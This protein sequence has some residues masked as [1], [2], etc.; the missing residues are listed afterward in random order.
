MNGEYI[1]IIPRHGDAINE[2]VF[3]KEATLHSIHKYAKSVLEF[4]EKSMSTHVWTFSAPIPNRIKERRFQFTGI[5]FQL[6]LTDKGFDNA[7]HY[8]APFSTYHIDENLGPLSLETHFN[9]AIGY[10]FQLYFKNSYQLKEK[11]FIIIGYVRD[12]SETDISF[13]TGWH[14]YISIGKSV[15]LLQLKVPGKKTFEQNSQHMPNGI[16]PENRNFLE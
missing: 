14:P 9:G 3:N 7:F 5:D 6:E 1:N 15:D 2:V 11:E 13:G 16:I 10:P 4:Q 12:E 8:E